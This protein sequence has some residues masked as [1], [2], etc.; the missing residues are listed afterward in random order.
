MR[1]LEL[2]AFD[3]LVQLAGRPERSA[4]VSLNQQGGV[5]Y[6]ARARVQQIVADSARLTERHKRRADCVVLRLKVRERRVQGDELQ[7]GFVWIVFGHVLQNGY[8]S[9]E[10]S[11]AVVIAHLR[12]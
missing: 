2:D 11:N 12:R 7:V 10:V 5:H 8:V 4:Y 1:P 3:L 9:A 6:R